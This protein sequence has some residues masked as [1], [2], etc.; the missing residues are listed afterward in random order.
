M[1][2]LVVPEAA[3][4]PGGVFARRDLPVGEVHLWH[5]DLDAAPGDAAVL[6]AEER[7]RADRMIGK[8]RGRFIRSREIIRRLLAS[9]VGGEP[10]AFAIEVAREGK[11]HL[12][13]N[14][15]RFNLA[16]TGPRW[17]AAFAADRDVGVDVERI[18]RD[19]DRDRVAARIFAPSEVATIRGLSG[20]AKTAAFFRCWTTREAIVKA[21]GEGM[22]TLASRFEVDADPEH[23]LGIRSLGAGAAG[24]HVGVVPTAPGCFAVLATEGEPTRIHA[25]DLR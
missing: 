13:P 8:A 23:P 11:P 5:A 16:H 17:L 24:L 22:F 25:W 4:P 15:I 2:S 20:E 19:V 12:V 9:Y 10:A 14:A 6:S 21:R 18:D 7:S 1:S 3:P